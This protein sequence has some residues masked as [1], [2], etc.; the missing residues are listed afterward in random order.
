M[1][2]R[3]TNGATSKQFTT[4]GSQIVSATLNPK[5]T[6]SSSLNSKGHATGCIITQIPAAN[7]DINII[8]IN[9][10]ADTWTAPSVPF[11]IPVGIKSIED[12]TANDVTGN[13][14]YE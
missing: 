9:G 2:G 10:D 7:T 6:T 1:L 12:S 3:T 5:R 14:I 11:E 8:T 4:D 13:F